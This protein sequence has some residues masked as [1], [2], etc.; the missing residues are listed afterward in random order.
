MTEL[1]KTSN[2]V[3]GTDGVTKALSEALKIWRGKG[4]PKQFIP[5]LKVYLFLE[6]APHLNAMREG[7][8]GRI[9]CFGE[10]PFSPT[11]PVARAE[12]EV[13]EQDFSHQELIEVI[14]APGPRISPGDKE[15]VRKLRILIN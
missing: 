15:L 4:Y 8:V 13:E 11:K 9:V 10:V 3:A 2:F 14:E 6:E 7:V 5:N 12:I 1:G